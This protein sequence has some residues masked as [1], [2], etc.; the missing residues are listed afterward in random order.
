MLSNQ[1]FFALFAA[2]VMLAAAA[3]EFF[4]NREVHA[5]LLVFCVL[6]AAMALVRR[7]RAPPS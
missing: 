5:G 6:L 2:A 3:I 4:V 1:S 7:P